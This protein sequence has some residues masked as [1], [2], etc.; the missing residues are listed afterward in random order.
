M[1]EASIDEQSYP[2]FR[3]CEIRF[4][5]DWPLLSVAA[6]PAKAEELLHLDFGRPPGRSDG[7]HDFRAN[8]SDTLIHWTLASGVGFQIFGL[9]VIC[10]DELI[11]PLFRDFNVVSS[12]RKFE[13]NY[14]VICHELSGD[15]PAC[16][17]ENFSL[18]HAMSCAV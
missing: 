9:D 7:R 16:Q 4:S 11:V 1:P 12:H 3:P 10:R 14:Y 8:F 18:Q 6:Y 13:Q 5:G 17:A 15:G 2:G